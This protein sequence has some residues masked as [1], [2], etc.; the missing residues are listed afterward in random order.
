MEEGIL[1]TFIK[2]VV[3]GLVAWAIKE[4]HSVKQVKEE[5]EKRAKAERE[6]LVK[7]IEV[8]EKTIDALVKM[9]DVHEETLRTL[10][11]DIKNLNEQIGNLKLGSQAL[12]RDRI[13]QSYNHY[14]VEKKWIPIYAKD[15]VVACHKSYENLG[16]NG[17][18]DGIMQQL[19]E[20]P[21]YEQKEGDKND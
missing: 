10:N 8:L 1:D 15:A 17:V 19:N 6:L 21:N 13:I 14:V 12:L 11:E 2:A 5:E 7:R 18:I 3:G 4:I 16:E 9:D 20:L